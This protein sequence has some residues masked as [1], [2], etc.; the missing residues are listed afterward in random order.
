[1]VEPDDGTVFL[2]NAGE[3][4]SLDHLSDLVRVHV[5]AAKIG[6]RG[7]CHLFRH[8]MATLM[9]EG[10]ADIRYIQAMLGHTDLKTTEIYTQVSIR[11]LKQIHTATHPARLA[12][13]NHQPRS[14]ESAESARA[15]L[16]STLDAEAEEDNE[17]ENRL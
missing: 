2:S 3:P 16:L 8:T 12:P 9:L 14:D 6:K 5:D 15:E 7:A 13:S 1:M 11:Q 10:G 4:F 17:A